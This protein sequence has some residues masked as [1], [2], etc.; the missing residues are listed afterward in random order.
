MNKKHLKKVAKKT[1]RSIRMIDFSLLNI[2]EYNKNYINNLLPHLNY[3]FKIFSEI[4]AQLLE[5]DKTLDYIVDFGGGHGFLSLFLKQL[6]LNVIYCDHNPES[7]KTIHAIKKE[8]GYGPDPIIEGSSSELLSFCKT[9]NLIPK[10]LI[11]T[12]LIEHVYDLNALFADFYVLNPDMSMI[13]T[14]G[15]VQTNILKSK[16]L[17]KMMIEEERNVYLPIRKQ[18]VLNNFPELTSSEIEKLAIRTRGLIFPDITQYVNNYLK[19]NDLPP[20]DV[21]KYNT[22]D[23]QTGNWTERILSKKQYRKI[24]NAHN[25]RVNFK[26]GFYNDERNNIFTSFAA[27]IVNIFIRRFSVSGSLFSPFLILTVKKWIK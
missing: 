11:A 20:V 21:D 2:S 8:I 5:N 15:S 27:K 13:F 18:F 12:D 23:P 9:K 6:G 7:V 3:C 1:I 10:Y 25:F 26:N 16:R 22:C 19:T 14:T 4:I 17:R 24:I